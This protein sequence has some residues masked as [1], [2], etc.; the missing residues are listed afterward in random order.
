MPD[1][2][3]PMPGSFAEFHA[4]LGTI[5]LDRILMLPPPGTATEADLLAAWIGPNHYRCELVDGTLI[6]KYGS[7]FGSVLVGE[8]CGE[9]GNSVHETDAG[10]ALMGNLPFR[11]RPGLIRLPSFTFTP[12]ERIPNEEL[13]DEEIA[14]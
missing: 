14:S 6:N 10:V 2:L 11:L 5:P 13:P 9:I 8:L 12:W 4:K 7:F 1:P 3:N